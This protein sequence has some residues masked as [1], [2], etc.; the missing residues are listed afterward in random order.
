[1]RRIDHDWLRAADRTQATVRQLSDQLR[2]FLDDRVWLENR[3]VMD[4]LRSIE[5]SAMALRGAA[6]PLTVGLDALS[7]RVA[8][9]FERPLYS[10]PAQASLH[11]AVADGEDQAEPES[12]FTQDHVDYQRVASSVRAALRHTRQVALTDLVDAHPLEQGLGEVM[13]YLGLSE[14]GVEVVFDDDAIEELRWELDDGALR[15]AELP[16]VAYVRTDLPAGRAG[17][18]AEGFPSGREGDRS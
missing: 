8:L 15:R 5:T 6:V 7:P 12:L 18:A 14:D 16:A 10:R 1:V 3:R 9:P 17:G 2:R 11:S 13:A 4:L